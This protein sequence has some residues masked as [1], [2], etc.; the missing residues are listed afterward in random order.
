MKNCKICIPN[1]IDILLL[2]L[3]HYLKITE[4]SHAINDDIYRNLPEI[5]YK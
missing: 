2:L 4:G 3:L 5:P 1:K